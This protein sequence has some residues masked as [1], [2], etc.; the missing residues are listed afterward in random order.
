MCFSA[1]TQAEGLSGGVSVNLGY[2]SDDA[3]RFG[4][5]SGVQEQ[6][7]YLGV[8]LNL[9]SDAD[10][11]QSRYWLLD[12]E[13][14][15][16][17][18]Y[19]V[20][21]EAGERGA[22]RVRVD[23][24]ALVNNA[25]EGAQSPFRPGNPLTLPNDWQVEGNN[26]A[27][28]LQLDE[29]LAPVDFWQERGRLRLDYRHDLGEQ[30]RL[31]A[32][33]RRE[34]K[35]GNRILGGVTGYSGGNNRAALLPAPVDY[36]THI[37]DLG[38][39]Y[40][41]DGYHW[42][43]A[44]H[45]SFYRSGDTG[46]AWPTP[47][48]QNP[49]WADG[50]G[51]PNGNNQ[52]ALEPDNQYH[53]LRLFAGMPLFETTRAQLDL[54]HGRMTQDQDYLP[55][56]LN[57]ALTVNEALPQTSLD[58]RVDTTHANL[59]LTSRPAPQWHLSQRL[60]YRDRDNRTPQAVYQRVRGDAENQQAFESGRINRPY[61]LTTTEFA[62]DAAYRLT[63]RVRLNAGYEYQHTERDYS[64]V[65]R[66]EEHALKLGARRTAS[67]TTAVSAELQHRQRR[68]SEYLDTLPYVQTHV[69]GT[70]GEDDFENHPLLRK[71]YL[72]DRDRDQLRLRADWFPTAEFSAG[73]NFI[74]NRDDYQDVVFGLDDSIMRSWMLDWSYA[75][76]EGVQLSGFASTD[77][78][79]SEQF[80]RSFRGNVPTDVDDPERDW[81]V[82]ARDR[83]D[84]YG[85]TLAW[86][87]VQDRLD[88]DWLSGP[89][90]LSL[91]WVNSRSRG[92]MNTYAGPALNHEPLPV[93]RT[94]LNHYRVNGDYQ[95]TDQ[96]AVRLSLEHERYTSADYALDDIAPDT[97]ANVLTLGHR[98]PR[99]NVT[100]V[101]L[102]YRYQF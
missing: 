19:R 57:P 89:L 65:R 9:E 90:N 18:D 73:L 14:L 88:W 92:E 99:Y 94:H 56:T 60:R 85:L 33:L 27:G 41:G 91:E 96:S 48:G 7:G 22:Y 2:L 29:S 100:W 16:L 38:L 101:V 31:N 5:Y 66:L 62:S 12:A 76:A 21:A 15:G 4:Q 45:G 84:T 87:N 78:Y 54:A 52:L 83:F 61:S 44:Y 26:T 47:F 1:A 3:P 81:Q 39:T 58:G 64:E 93:L 80:G 63:R 43:F 74:Y 25:I 42:G 68:G 86:D 40:Q 35:T 46:L 75:A 51:Y 36:E 23:Y 17:D 97:A 95:V 50:V 28:L 72:A 8:D 70:I 55:Y 53:Q 24:Q 82:A 11:R 77:R 32:E 6:G 79:A 67:A 10:Y 59:R 49:Q 20:S 30:W 71:Y 102:G 34:T 69:P 37:A 98:S 13:R